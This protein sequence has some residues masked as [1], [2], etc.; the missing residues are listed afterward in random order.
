[1][2]FPRKNRPLV[3]RARDRRKKE[4]TRDFERKRGTGSC[5]PASPILRPSL[6]ITST[7]YPPTRGKIFLS[8]PEPS[9]FTSHSHTFWYWQIEWIYM[10][11][12]FAIFISYAFA[13]YREHR[14]WTE[15]LF[16]TTEYYNLQLIC[17]KDRRYD[18][19]IERIVSNNYRLSR[20]ESII[21]DK[22]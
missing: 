5:H 4:R 20:L 19:L 21:C 10:K 7:R 14:Y 2:D 18:F 15:Y 1:M 9:I 12:S 3:L 6:L 22:I 11:Q 13:W 16:R 17:C 8:D